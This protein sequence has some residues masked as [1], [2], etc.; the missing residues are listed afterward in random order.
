MVNSL[1]MEG[2][3]SAVHESQ[4][5]FTSSQTLVKNIATKREIKTLEKRTLIRGKSMFTI[6][7]NEAESTNVTYDTDVVI[8]GGETLTEKVIEDEETEEMKR[9]DNASERT[10][11]GGLGR[12]R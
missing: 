10:E 4:K 1:D 12:V 11:L 9:V 6:S 8:D 7:T 3:S 5:T 2:N